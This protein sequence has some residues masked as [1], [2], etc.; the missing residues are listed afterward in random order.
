MDKHSARRTFSWPRGTYD[1][2]QSSTRYVSW[3][4]PAFCSDPWIW[5]M[6]LI[7]GSI[8]GSDPWI[9]SMGSDPWFRSMDLMPGPD[10][11][12]RWNVT[13]STNVGQNRLS[14]LAYAWK[15]S[16]VPL[17]HETVLRALCLSRIGSHPSPLAQ[18]GQCFP[19][20]TRRLET[21]FRVLVS[22]RILVKSIKNYEFHD[23]AELRPF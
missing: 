20:S 1:N 12:I 19:C 8:H 4:W 14:Y 11:W 5:S 10:P 23:L 3:F 22:T 2:S 18:F 21:P 15:F 13:E 17:G 6:N 9:R 16:Y 7:H